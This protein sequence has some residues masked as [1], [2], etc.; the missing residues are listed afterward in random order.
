MERVVGTS[1]LHRRAVEAAVWGQPI[2]MFDAMRQA[3]FR[4]A[5][6]KYNDVIWWPR[7]ADWR[8]QNLTPNTVARYIF[9]FG[10]IDQDGPV[11]FELPG[12]VTG[13]GFLGTFSDAWWEPLAD[14]GMAGP[15][16]GK[17]GKYLVLPA[18]HD[19]EVPPGYIPVRTRTANYFMGLADRWWLDR[20]LGTHRAIVRDAPGW[21]HLVHA[22]APSRRSPAASTRRSISRWRRSA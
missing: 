19:G 8:S 14:L 6:A 4:D 10:N 9:F 1:V 18:D 20:P 5:Q 12:G 13:A 22:W 3:Y 7:G 11:V 15:D 21:R 2:V 16:E 17:G